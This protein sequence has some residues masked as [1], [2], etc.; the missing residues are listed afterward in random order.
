[1]NVEKQN[2]EQRILVFG[3]PGFYEQ[4]I[5]KPLRIINDR[6]ADQH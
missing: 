6:K 1:M 5:N 4:Y 3:H 2:R